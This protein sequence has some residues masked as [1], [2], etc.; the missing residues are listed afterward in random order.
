MVNRLNYIG[1][2]HLLFDTIY[3]DILD[4][5]GYETLKGRVVGDVFSGT[6]IVSW[7][8]RQLG[9][10]TH[11]NDAELYSFYVT[12]AMALCSYTPRVAAVISGLNTDAS[13]VSGFITRTYSPYEGCERQ[14]FTIENA[15]R[16]DFMRNSIRAMDLSDHERAFLLASLVVSAD[17]VSNVPAVYG[18]YLK[19]FKAKALKTLVLLPVHTLDRLPEAL[20]TVQNLDVLQLVTPRMHVAYLDPPYNERQYSKNYFPLNV[21]CGEDMAVHGKTGIPDECFVSPFCSRRV[22]A[23]VFEQLVERTNAT[24][25][26]ISY[27]SEGIVS[28]DAF[29]ALLE[30]F[31]EVSVTEF[32]YKRFKSFSYNEDKRVTEYLFCLHKN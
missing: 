2:K 32:D 18:M 7:N 13:R 6:G 17:A 15:E 23:D 31:G 3:K 29:T 12:K 25:I 22:A 19:Q 10:E 16:I 5:T 27:N 9:A 28:R 8:M 20:S 1:S 14:F 21:I 4:K 24:W 11:S 26:F 30:K